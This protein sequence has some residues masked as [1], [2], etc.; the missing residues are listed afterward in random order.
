MSNFVVQTPEWEWLDGLIFTI[1]DFPSPIVLVNAFDN[2][3]PQCFRLLNAILFQTTHIFV[4]SHTHYFYVLN[5]FCLLCITM[6][7]YD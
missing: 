6:Y 3:Y 4:Y 5:S 2:F 7:V 1:W